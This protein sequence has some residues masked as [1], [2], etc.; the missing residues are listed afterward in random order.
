[1]LVVLYETYKVLEQYI[2]SSP[3]QINLQIVTD[4]RV[5]TDLIK[6]ERVLSSN[7]AVEPGL[8]EGRPAVAELMRTSLV[9]LADPGDS[10]VHDLLVHRRISYREHRYGC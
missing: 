9:L 3:T 7:R 6:V 10:R 2:I 8:E 4:I 5:L 1:M